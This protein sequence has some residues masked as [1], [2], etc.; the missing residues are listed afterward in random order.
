MCSVN[1]DRLRHRTCHIINHAQ[2]RRDYS[3]PRHYLA[4]PLHFNPT[5]ASALCATGRENPPARLRRLL[6]GLESR[7]NAGGA[8]FFVNFLVWPT[9]HFLNLA[10]RTCV[11][12]I[13]TQY[14]A[15]NFTGYDR[16]SKHELN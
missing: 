6:H 16:K 8:F 1:V 4:A 5:F 3:R 14:N 9:E 15:G 12:G 7:A 2:Q 13:L 11:A 10:T